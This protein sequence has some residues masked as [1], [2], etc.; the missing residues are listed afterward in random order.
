MHSIDPVI[1]SIIAMSI[2]CC[3]LVSVR[4]TAVT[5]PA[6]RAG[7]SSS[8]PRKSFIDVAPVRASV[9]FFYDNLDLAAQYVKYGV[10]AKATACAGA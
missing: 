10:G 5:S 7:E 8:T 2:C 3:A 9:S 6:M 1:S 4:R